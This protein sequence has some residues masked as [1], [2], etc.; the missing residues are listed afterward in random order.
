M[1]VNTRRGQSTVPP[2]FDS[3]SDSEGEE[4]EEDA[5]I[6]TALETAEGEA[7]KADDSEEDILSEADSEPETTRTAPRRPAPR[8][9][10][11]WRR[12]EEQNVLLDQTQVHNLGVLFD[13][14][15]ARHNGLLDQLLEVGCAAGY[16]SHGTRVYG[17]IASLSGTLATLRVCS[18]GLDGR[19]VTNVEL[20]STSFKRLVPKLQRKEAA[21]WADKVG[22]LGGVAELRGHYKYYCR[23]LR[24]KHTV[25]IWHARVLEQLRASEHA[26]NFNYDRFSQTAILAGLKAK[27]SHVFVFLFLLQ[28]AKTI[29]RRPGKY[30][31]YRLRI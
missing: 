10:R 1:V 27:E 26:T 30:P 28:K 31:T 7:D 17:T 5:A 18:L 19:S 29:V 3:S 25:K 4:A 15:Q 12:S 22:L 14:Y 24:R 9:R 2:G 6:N 16:K 13:D 11:R 20:P 21:E 8:R 23:V